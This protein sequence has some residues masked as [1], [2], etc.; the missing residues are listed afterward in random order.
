MWMITRKRPGP[1]TR[2]DAKLEAIVGSRKNRDDGFRAIRPCAKVERER[3]GKVQFR[4]P[5]PGLSLGRVGR[6]LPNTVGF[7]QL[8]DF[9]LNEPN[10]LGEYREIFL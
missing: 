2:P 4:A 10:D 8:D 9:G 7:T 6:I 1:A 3:K 5:C